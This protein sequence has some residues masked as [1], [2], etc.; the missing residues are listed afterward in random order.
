MAFCKSIFIYIPNGPRVEI[1]LEEVEGIEV[2]IPL[3]LIRALP[4]YLFLL[5]EIKL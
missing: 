1:N 5:V 2:K 3:L 4:V